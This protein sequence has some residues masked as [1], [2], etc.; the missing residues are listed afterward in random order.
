MSFATSFGHALGPW[1]TR[2]CGKFPRGSM[3]AAIL[4]SILVPTFVLIPILVLTFVFILIL[5]FIRAVVID[6][7]TPI[8]KLPQN[9]VNWVTYLPSA[10]VQIPPGGV[11]ITTRDYTARKV[12]SGI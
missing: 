10:G 12:V 5:I 2:I 1:L 7:I 4:I 8:D 11:G 9:E 3:I 6:S